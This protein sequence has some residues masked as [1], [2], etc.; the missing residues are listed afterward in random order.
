VK[1]IGAAEKQEFEDSVCEFLQSCISD[2]QTVPAKTKGDGGLDGYSDRQTV[3]YCC[4]GPEQ[5]SFKDNTKGLKADIIKKFSTDLRKVF[6]LDPNKANPTKKNNPGLEQVLA[7]GVKLKTIRLVVSVFEEKAIL[8]KLNTAFNKYVAAS[9]LRFVEKNCSLVVWGPA[10]L[11][12]AGVVNDGTVVRLQNRIMRARL[13]EVAVNAT[14][15]E[16]PAP[17]EGFDAKFDWLRD[18]ADGPKAARLES[19]R[20]RFLKN[21]GVALAIQD[22]L[23]NNAVGLHQDLESA[24]ERASAAA[25]LLSLEGCNPHALLRTVSEEMKQQLKEKLGEHLKLSTLESLADG[26]VAGLVGE[27]PIDWRTSS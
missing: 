16:P 25:D 3:G 18:R 13:A 12:A 10:Q 5:G 20:E 23:A 2:F 17:P 24:R 8:G 9:D 22:D 15:Q 6:E 21:W 26:E 11:A 27:C 14:K 1:M 4:Y 7:E 19:I